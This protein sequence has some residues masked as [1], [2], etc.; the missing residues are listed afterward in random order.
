MDKV[1]T[2]DGPSGVGKWTVSRLVAEAL[3]WRYL[4]SGAIYRVAA[5]ACL[6][7]NIDLHDIARIAALCAQLDVEFKVA[8]ADKVLAV[9]LQGENVSDLIRTEACGNGASQISVHPIIRAALL[10]RQRDFLTAAGLV[11]DG[12]DMGTVV[13]PQATIKIFL[14]ASPTERANRRYKQLKE[15]GIDI[16]FED[17]V[18]ELSERDQRDSER[19]HA[20]LTPAEDAVMLS[21]DGLTAPEVVQAIMAVVV[22]IIPGWNKVERIED[23]DY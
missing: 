14:T 20:P 23:N 8:S 15:K 5:L 21:T 11:T 18:K 10:Q 3:G 1:I 19:S 22:K 4:D 17:L 13:F 16:H 9:Y 6:Q 12:R 2:V 7:N